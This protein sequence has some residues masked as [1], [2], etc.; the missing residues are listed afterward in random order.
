LAQYKWRQH[1]FL[2]PLK[3]SQVE[4]EFPREPDPQKDC[5]ERY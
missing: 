1:G 2:P 5:P 4:V 3:T